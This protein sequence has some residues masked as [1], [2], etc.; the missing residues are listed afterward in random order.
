MH[1][2]VDCT[3]LSGFYSNCSNPV[4]LRAFIK[5]FMPHAVSLET[6]VVNKERKYIAQLMSE[7][8]FVKKLLSIKELKKELI[9]TLRAQNKSSNT[10]VNVIFAG[11]T[12]INYTLNT[13][14]QNLIA[15]IEGRLLREAIILITLTMSTK[16]I[17]RFL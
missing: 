16:L 8:A 11:Y 2:P 3:P 12:L 5:Y 10:C 4:R 17:C 15:L 6:A 13:G 7:A 14:S 9:Q 1:N